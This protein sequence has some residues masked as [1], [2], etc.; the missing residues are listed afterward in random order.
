MPAILRDARAGDVLLI[1]VVTVLGLLLLIANP[2]YFSHDE[3]QRL[4]QVEQYGF[5]DYVRLVS[6]YVMLTQ[7]DGLGVPVRPI[8]FFIQGLLALVM[9]DYPVI[10]HL[11]DVLTHGAVAVLL[12]FMLLRFGL[13]RSI[14][15]WSACIF[16][17]NPMAVIATGWSAALMDR[18]YVLFGICALMCVDSHVRRRAS[19]AMLGL[20]VALMLAAILSKE[21]AIMLPG[22]M[23]IFVLLDG[24]VLKER[25]FWQAS[26][27][28]AFPVLMYL[29]YRI[30]AIL[31]SFNGTA[32]GSYSA[33]LG[34]VLEGLPV[35]FA[36]PFLITLTE[37]VH[38]V[39]VR[40]PL[41]AAALL[42]HLAVVGVLWAKAGWRAAAGYLYCYLLFLFPVLFLP[43]KAAHYL[44]ASSAVFSVALAWIL[45]GPGPWRSLSSSAAVLVLALMLIHSI[46]LQNFV[47]R[48]GACMNTA[49]TGV[50]ALHLTLGR[51]AMLELRAEP[52]APAHVL[53]R[54]T[55][56]RS[57]VGGVSPVRLTVVDWDAPRS[58]GQALIAMDARC[59][60]YAAHSR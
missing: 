18:W 53:H 17:L 40:P 36:Y 44:Y 52:G 50:E 37:A 3:L 1:L 28:M 11:V 5:L 51:P 58:E 20:V 15:L 55:T 57:R 39:F 54:F 19:M 21:T 49:M 9:R 31:S 45:V 41:M 32:T 48:L 16:A 42:A 25:R 35:Y 23:L 8:A 6:A 46:V 56:G 38:W 26:V 14:A 4:D 59:R 60:V 33:S 13:S 34:N 10:V 30:P 27:A 22:L 12:F 29:A 47:Y 2:G 43:I 24:S 7:G